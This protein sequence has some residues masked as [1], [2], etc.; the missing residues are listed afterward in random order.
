MD[1]SPVVS[2]YRLLT[3]KDSM[4]FISSRGATSF[5]CFTLVSIL[6]MLFLFVNPSIYQLTPRIRNAFQSSRRYPFAKVFAQ[7]FSNASFAPPPSVPPSNARDKTDPPQ[8]F[9]PASAPSPC[10]VSRKV[11]P[12]LLPKETLR[13]S[14]SS[15]ESGLLLHP[16]SEENGL[17][18]PSPE[19]PSL[20]AWPPSPN[21]APKEKHWMEEW[22][23]C[24]VYEGSWVR[25]DSYPLYNAGSCPYIHG[26]FNCF[27][28]GREDNMYEKYR[29][30]PKNCKVPR[31]FMKSS[32][33][34]CVRSNAFFATLKSLRVLKLLL[35][36]SFDIGA[37]ATLSVNLLS[38]S[39]FMRIC[40][41]RSYEIQMFL[42][43]FLFECLCCC[44]FW[45]LFSEMS[46]ERRLKG[47]EM[48]EILRGKRL[49][50]V[51]DSL[52]RNMWESLVCT[53][54]HSLEDKSRMLDEEFL[55]EGSCSMIFQ[56]WQNVIPSLVLLHLFL[57]T[58]TGQLD[59]I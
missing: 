42:F 14:D 40:Q 44:T 56:V 34:Q 39:K 46:N 4:R 12:R 16:P 36:F 8:E 26:S 24:D 59:T 35:S 25:D 15:Y 27:A 2:R 11:G 37:T 21:A 45:F 41:A 9:S 50:F 29:W 47:N 53:L 7:I 52:N 33:Y 18:A 5:G 13:N 23:G 49:V 28:N 43:S 51:G 10:Q 22:S 57:L 54:R 1:D 58:L 6:F 31:Y 19:E 38:D 30:Q 32:P 55:P 3:R 20:P 17:H 48:L